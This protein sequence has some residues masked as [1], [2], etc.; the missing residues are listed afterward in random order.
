MHS[1]ILS[2]RTP[3][4]EKLGIL[5]S[6]GSQ[7]VRH[8]WVT[9]TFTSSFAFLEAACFDSQ[10][11][12]ALS[13]PGGIRNAKWEIKIFQNPPNHYKV[14]YLFHICKGW[15]ELHLL[16]SRFQNRACI[17]HLNNSPNFWLCLDLEFSGS[18]SPTKLQTDL[19][20]RQV[21]MC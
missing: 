9:F 15:I 7:R 20:Q 17:S 12:Y 6:L 11:Q 13:L 16:N 4:T 10:S 18:S 14:L 5:Q 19:Q 3:W 21:F 8:D 2:W 1:S